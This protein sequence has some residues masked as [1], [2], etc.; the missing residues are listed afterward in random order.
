M[1]GRLN[2]LTGQ[3]QEEKKKKKQ[4]PERA[5]GRA[6]DDYCTKHGIFIR[7]IK[8]TGT[9]RGGKW[10]RSAMGKGISDR[11]G[12][13]YPSGRFIAIELKAPGKKN[14]VTPEQYDY[15]LKVIKAGGVG[16]LADRVEDVAAALLS[17][18]EA[19]LSTLKKFE[20]RTAA[21]P[22]ECLPDWL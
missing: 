21:T 20:P 5:V 16:V 4:S 8:T 3:W 6:V 17:S 9:Q 10:T 15:L 14:T 12:C 22:T 1:S 13:I 7:E 2:L 18:K 11:I 19:L